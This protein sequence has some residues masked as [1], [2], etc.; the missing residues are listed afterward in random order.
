MAFSCFRAFESCKDNTE[1]QPQEFECPGQIRTGHSGS[2]TQH[3]H[4]SNKIG[5]GGFGVVYKRNSQIEESYFAV[6][7]RSP[8][9][10]YCRNFAAKEGAGRQWSSSALRVSVGSP[11]LRVARRRR[12]LCS[13]LLRLARR[14]RSRGL[15]PSP[16]GRE[17][18]KSPALRV[19]VWPGEDEV[20]A[21]AVRRVFA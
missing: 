4:P 14:R 9:L 6:A 7:A 1:E 8:R 10:D 5:G 11:R 15:F 3:F 17:K 19:S 18:M 2:A 13:P 21:A 16:S 12:S 20:C